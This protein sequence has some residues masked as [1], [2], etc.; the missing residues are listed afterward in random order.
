MNRFSKSY[1]KLKGWNRHVAT[2]E[3]VQLA[4][5]LDLRRQAQIQ[6]Q[7]ESI[8]R[9]LG[10]QDREPAKRAE[11]EIRALN[12]RLAEMDRKLAWR[13]S[14]M[15]RTLKCCRRA[16]R[17]PLAYDEIREIERIAGESDPNVV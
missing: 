1:V 6:R 5:E 7:V 4:K 12:G 13:E 3:E 15:D 16:E 14:Q 17:G 8:N 11:L 10:L 9:L 2:E